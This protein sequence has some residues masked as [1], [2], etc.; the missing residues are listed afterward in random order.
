MVI[1]ERNVCFKKAHK[2]S[3]TKT[4]M[5]GHP[6]PYF[7]LLAPS[8]NTLY[9]QQV[10]S[11]IWSPAEYEYENDDEGHLDSFD[12]GFWNETSGAGSPTLV[13]LT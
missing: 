11:K 6:T 9:L 2:G 7:L 4:M 13:T 5:L 8:F 12:F 10:E 1:E 3:K